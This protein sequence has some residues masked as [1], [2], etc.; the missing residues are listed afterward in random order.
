MRLRL[1]TDAFAFVP[2]LAFLC[3][4][5]GTRKYGFNKFF[6]KTRSHSTIH[7]FKNYFATVFS[8]FS[9]KRYP[10]RPLADLAKRYVFSSQLAQ[11]FPDI[12]DVAVP[13]L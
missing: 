4:I 11:I 2:S 6:F 5:H 13:Y 3:T 8:I 7:I 12:Y 1:D 9:N 10:N